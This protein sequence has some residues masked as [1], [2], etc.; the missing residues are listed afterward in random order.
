MVPKIEKEN[1]F[2]YDVI[3]ATPDMMGIIGRLGKVL[4]PKGLMPNP[5]SGTVTM[6]VTKAISEIKSGKVEYR[7]DKTNIIHL[8]FGKVSFGKE[9]L[10]ENY[11]T[12]MDAII[13]AKPSAAKGQYIKSIGISTT[14]GP[15]IYV[16]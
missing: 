2:D 10:L 1:W 3:V 16:E 8:G 5:K 15:G 9:K 7:L 12:V 13:K 4:G 11:N 14:M 6:D